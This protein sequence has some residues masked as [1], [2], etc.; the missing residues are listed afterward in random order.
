MSGFLPSSPPQDGLSAAGAIID[1]EDALMRLPL[2][3]GNSHRTMQGEWREELIS[4]PPLV[5]KVQQPAAFDPTE[6]KRG[7]F[8]FEHVAA[9]E[10]PYIVR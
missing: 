4:I 10:R 6:L 8:E 5:G 9:I 2:V 1:A 7:L 3:D